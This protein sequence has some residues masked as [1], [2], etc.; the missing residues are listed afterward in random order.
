MDTLV[1]YSALGVTSDRS[2]SGGHFKPAAVSGRSASGAGSSDRSAAAAAAAAAHEW[3]IGGDG[4]GDE[5]R[6]ARSD[7][8][9]SRSAGYHV[10]RPAVELAKARRWNGDGD[11]GGDSPPAEH[12]Y[13]YCR[14]KSTAIPV[15]SV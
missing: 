3:S 2:E 7:H 12:R 1:L 13:S 9:R 4:A 10:T 5:V 14:Y 6:V 11:G 8:R 15:A